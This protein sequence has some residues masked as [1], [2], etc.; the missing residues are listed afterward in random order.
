MRPCLPKKPSFFSQM[1]KGAST[2]I[3]KPDCS[4]CL[5]FWRRKKKKC[6]YSYTW[7]S[8]QRAAVDV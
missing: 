5:V 7:Y 6:Y 3:A 4:V 8:F 2:A 1:L